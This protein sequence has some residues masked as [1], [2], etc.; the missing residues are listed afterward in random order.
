MNVPTISNLECAKTYGT[1]IV[2]ANVICTRNPDKVKGPC[3]H[4]AG[5]P[6]VINADTDPV[7]VGIFSVLGEN[8]CNNNYPAVYVRTYSYTNWIKE[9]TNI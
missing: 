3:V 5:N 7:H 1:T 2:D 4:D 6:L 9:K 8:G